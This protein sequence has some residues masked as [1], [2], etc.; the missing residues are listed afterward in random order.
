MGAKT[1]GLDEVAYERLR[2]EKREDVSFGEVVTENVD[3]V[4]QLGVAVEGY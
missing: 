2:A 4:E 1:I 3:D